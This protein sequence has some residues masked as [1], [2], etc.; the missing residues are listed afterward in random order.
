M[1]MDIVERV[2]K[3]IYEARPGG[4]NW[5]ALAAQRNAK[6]ERAKWLTMARAALVAADVPW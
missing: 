2:A 3:A 6:Y 1:M 4:G 5:E